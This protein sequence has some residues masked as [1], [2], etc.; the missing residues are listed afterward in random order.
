MLDN[1]SLPESREKHSYGTGTADSLKMYKGLIYR[2][3]C[4]LFIPYLVDEYQFPDVP[5]LELYINNIK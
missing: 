4:M 3:A 1:Y 2:D 5:D